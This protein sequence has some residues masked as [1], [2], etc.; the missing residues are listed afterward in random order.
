MRRK[1]TT[2]LIAA[3]LAASITAFAQ[4]TAGG[5]ATS[6][7]VPVA[8]PVKVGIINI[9]Q[10]ILATN[11]GRREFEVLNTKFK[12]KQDELE[13]GGKDLD[14]MRQQLSTQGDKMN[15]EAR[16]T[17]VKQIDAKQR[18]LQ[19]SA[20]DAQTDF[21]SQQQEIAQRILQKLAPVVDKFA[22]QNGYAL[23]IDDSNPW[24]QGQVLW[25][26]DSVDVT[27][28]VVDTFN[29]QSGVAA[30][31][32]SAPSATRPAPVASRP[33][34]GAPAAGGAAARPPATKPPQP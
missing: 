3:A 11:E 22:K 30:P 33:A 25:A 16:A 24:P 2:F 18:A 20:D 19:R 28:A 1:L 34:V 12:P 9:Q 31:T 23:L 27:K 14:A 6:A 21:N 17:L 15:E 10:A 32:A 4:G 29:A 13:K 7:A 5:G 8:A 26:T